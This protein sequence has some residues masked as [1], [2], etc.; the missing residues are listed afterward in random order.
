VAFDLEVTLPNAASEVQL[1]ASRFV[2]LSRLADDLAHEFKNPL[3]AIVINLEVLKRRVEKGAVDAA[4]ERTGVLEHEVQRL[5]VLLEAL[6]RLMRPERSS[7]GPASVGQVLEEI[8]PI[9]ELR[10]R[11][12]RVEYSQDAASLEVYTSV[13]PDLF[14]FSLIVIADVLLEAA[15]VNGGELQLTTRVLDEEIQLRMKSTKGADWAVRELA[16]KPEHAATLRGLP[17]AM[18]LLFT[19]GGSMELEQQAEPG[20]SVLIRIPRSSFV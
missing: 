5:H 6:L 16:K 19:T 17:A 8:R 20:V 15:S 18:A 1:D 2:A 3:H 13:K 9:L 12:A 7:E 14:R 10:A 4:L 11:I